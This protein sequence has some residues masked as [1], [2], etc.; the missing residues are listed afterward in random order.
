MVAVY[1]GLSV[2]VLIND[3][4]YPA[5]GWVV[6][7]SIIALDVDGGFL[8]VVVIVGVVELDTLIPR[9]QRQTSVEISGSPGI[10]LFESSSYV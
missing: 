2:V 7:S 8:L 4:V 9:Y 10:H 3:P 6:D 1:W 5:S